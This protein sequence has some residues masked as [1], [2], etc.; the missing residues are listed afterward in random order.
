MP[1]LE[2]VAVAPQP[3]Q[4]S[5]VGAPLGPATTHTHTRPVSTLI[6]FS[7]QGQGLSPQTARTQLGLTTIPSKA[8]HCCLTLS[9]TPATR[10]TPR[11]PSP[12]GPAAGSA[13]CHPAACPHSR[14]RRPQSRTAAALHNA[15]STH[16]RR[17]NMHVVRALCSWCGALHRGWCDRPCRGLAKH[18]LLRQGVSLWRCLQEVKPVCN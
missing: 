13:P 2:G 1:H 4:H 14:Q 17:T 5:W 10:P 18:T 7:S 9:C 6:T 15:A 11:P 8:P 3:L 12:R 16:A